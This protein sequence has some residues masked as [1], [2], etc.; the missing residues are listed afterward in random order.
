MAIL[1]MVSYILANSLFLFIRN[2]KLVPNLIRMNMK[3]L[4]P[5]L[6]LAIGRTLKL[7]LVNIL[8]VLAEPALSVFIILS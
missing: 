7:S 6:W 5:F 2:S 8:E 3:R 4:K 1:L